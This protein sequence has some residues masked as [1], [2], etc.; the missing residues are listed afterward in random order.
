MKY[1]LV[2]FMNS[3]HKVYYRGE[4]VADLPEEFFTYI[5]GVADTFGVGEIIFMIDGA[6][7]YERALI[8]PEYKA[9]R[10][11]L[12]E[13]FTAFKDAVKRLVKRTQ[14][15]YE[16]PGVEAD[17][18]IAS[19]VNQ[20]RE[21]AKHIYILS[22]DLDLC[23]LTGG[24]VT[25]LK[26]IG[27]ASW[28]NLTPDYLEIRYGLKAHQIKDLK[29]I[30]GDSSD[31]YKGAKGIGDKWAIRLLDRYGSIESIYDLLDKGEELDELFPKGL[32]Q[33]LLDSRESVYLCKNL[34]TLR[35]DKCLTTPIQE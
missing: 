22:T 13:D 14:T 11:S 25:Q 15:Y 19:F 33:K 32:K 27:E 7:P 29:G 17:D 6:K 12:P 23:Q 3:L 1:L 5:N 31:N 21:T 4:T 9:Q 10:P 8:Y 2:D 35:T 18:L 28:E 24:N 16:Q 26:V 30:A 20:N 34:A